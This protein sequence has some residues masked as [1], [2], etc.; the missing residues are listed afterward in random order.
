MSRFHQVTIVG[1]GL[2]GGSLGM[3][4]RRKHLAR[5][6]VG[7]SR[8]ARTLRL[9]K[10]R[11]AID[12]G[13]T[14][15]VRAARGADL[16][17]LATPVDVI[18]PLA[19]RL[20][21]VMRYGAVL[22]DV[23]STKGEI[24]RTLQRRLPAHVAFV[25]AHPLAGSERRGIDAARPKLFQDSLCF[26]TPTTQTRPAAVRAVTRLWAPLVCRVL[27]MSPERHDRLVA[28]M[29]H[30]P[31]V[32]ACA[33]TSSA[34]PEGLAVAPRSFLEMTRIA[35]SDPDLWDD[36][37]LSNRTAVLNAMTE[38]EREWR[39]LRAAL[40]RA[41]RPALRRRLAAAQARRKSLE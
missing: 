19:L 34:P 24:V 9:A 29:S 16:V 17:I 27:L 1:L 22:S 11:G 30:L 23:G 32:V 3:A 35:G 2:I 26:L 7:V 33:L 41:D 39:A 21:R 12:V 15:P 36:I 25:G 6:V 18:V 14:D 10:R 28:T 8:T 20:A 38:F 5:T 13:M 4:L 40:V 31:H 37:F